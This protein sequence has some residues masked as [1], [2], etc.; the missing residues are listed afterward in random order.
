MLVRDAAILVAFFLVGSVFLSFAS[1][2]SKPEAIGHVTGFYAT[3]GG[4]MFNCTNAKV[5]IELIAPDLVRVKLGPQGIFLEDYSW[6]VSKGDWP[7]FEWEVKELQDFISI[8][9]PELSIFVQKK[10]FMIS[11]MDK[12]GNM[13]NRDIAPMEWSENGIKC[14]KKMPLDEHYYGFGEKT[15]MLDKRRSNMTMWNT[16][17][18]GYDNNTDPLYQSIPFFIGLKEEA[19]GI[20]FDNTYKSYFDMGATSEDRYFFGSDGG[21]MDYYFFFGPN[22]KKVVER[23]TELTGKPFMPPLWALGHQISRYSYYPQERIMEIAERFREEEIP[24]DTIYLDIHYHEDYKPF[25]WDREKFPDPKAMIDELH[26][27]GFRV[28]TIVDPAIK[29]EHGY[30]PYEEG[31]INNYFLMLENG[32]VYRDYMWPGLCVWPDFT[33]EEVRAWWGELYTELIEQGVDG[34]WNDM[35]EPSVFNETR[36]PKKTMVNNTVFF[37]HGLNTTHRK[38]HNVYALTELMGTYEGL[39]NLMDG[40]RQFVLSR[41]GFAGIQRYAATWTGD[42][43]ASWEHL[44]LQIPMF[45]N[46]GLSGLSFTGSDI[47]GFVGTPSPELLVRWYEASAFVPLCR[48]HTAIETYDQEPWV[49][50]DYYE[51]IIR[52]YLNLRY[53]LLPY[54][55]GLCYESSVKGYPILRP[56]IFEFQNDEEVYTIEDEFMLGPSILVAPV[57]KEGAEERLIYLPEGTWWDYWS[58]EPLEGPCWINYRAP[59]DKLPIFVRGGSIIPV[60]KPVQHTGSFQDITVNIYP[61][62]SGESSYFLYEDDGENVDSPFSLINFTLEEEGKKIYFTAKKEGS[63]DAGREN[64]ELKFHGLDVGK[65]DLTG[66]RVNGKRTEGTWRENCLI[67]DVP[68]ES[69]VEVTLTVRGL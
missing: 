63:Y 65:P 5:L 12:S 49:Y 23:Y 24:T 34:I 59:L 40:K 69:T 20:F 66:V 22:I 51:S 62:L 26:N 8:N 2:D 7:N 16:D 44:A 57:L 39:K 10:P 25:T 17:A 48:D 13:I 46:M 19:Y 18:Y 37:D 30:E 58:D 61:N 67:I 68:D 42:N 55:Y 60:Q 41:A 32:S 50:G 54:M 28:I 53:S 27:M 14:T 38:N 52:D 6:A 11:F 3:E 1:S 64:M 4:V 56:L 21:E 43:T 45:L 35:N 29:V 31:T 33:R 9:T 47:G 15:G 36:E